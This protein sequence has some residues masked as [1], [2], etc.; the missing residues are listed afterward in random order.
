MSGEFAEG[1]VVGLAISF[2][3]WVGWIVLSFLREPVWTP[4]L[5]VTPIQ[6]RRRAREKPRIVRA[7]GEWWC[8]SPGYQGDGY[9][10]SEAFRNWESAIYHAEQYELAWM[11]RRGGNV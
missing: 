3:V 7:Y 5:C 6:T 8:S 4:P 2:G 11:R 10:P 1:V 9:S